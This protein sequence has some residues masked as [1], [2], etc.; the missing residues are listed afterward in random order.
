M[1]DSYPSYP[2][3]A[4]VILESDQ[5]QVLRQP[6][7]YWSRWSRDSRSA[8]LLA[9]ERPGAYQ[10]TARTSI[11][12][13]RDDLYA[14]FSMNPHLRPRSVRLA[15]LTDFTAVGNVTLQVTVSGE[16]VPPPQLITD[17][18]AAQ[19]ISKALSVDYGHGHAYRTATS[20]D[21]SLPVQL[22]QLPFSVSFDAF[23]VEGGKDYPMGWVHCLEG[24]RAH[25]TL[26]A[27]GIQYG[28]DPTRLKLVPRPAVLEKTVTRVYAGQPVEI[29]VMVVD[30]GER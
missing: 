6:P 22:E 9:P 3:K 4:E 29:E 18:E 21:A 17:P 16:P 24:S 5:L 15:D 30:Y 7:R 12:L 20:N 10:I 8:V 2:W 11:A 19:A 13:T 1:E 27:T 25:W 26:T 28:N 23:L 14:Q